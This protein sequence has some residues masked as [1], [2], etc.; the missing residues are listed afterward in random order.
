[1]IKKQ[2]DDLLVNIY[3]TREEMGSA[4][5]HDAGEHLRG[6]LKA[7][8]EVNCIFAA[9]PSQ[10]EFLQALCS[11][12]DIEWSRINAFHMDEYCGLKQGSHGSFSGFLA[13]AVFNKLPFKSVSYIN[14]TNDIQKECARYEALLKQYPTDV[15]FMGIGENGHIAFND[16]PV[17]DFKDT[18][19]VKCV[20]LDF[21]CRQQQVNDKCFKTISAVPTHAFTVTVPGLMRAA[22]KF[23]IVPGKLKAPAVKNTLKGAVS[24]SCPASILRTQKGAILY[25][26]TNSASLII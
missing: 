26:D 20:E 19:L 13:N 1:M 18:A 21:A 14:G 9:A 5:A 4:A 16:P 2:Y 24:E 23:C 22:A 15:V 11:M 10:N 8:P 17:A 6:L 7:K 25:L 12:T 3:S